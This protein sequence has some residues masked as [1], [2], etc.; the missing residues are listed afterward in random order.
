MLQKWLDRYK[1]AKNDGVGPLIAPDPSKTSIELGMTH[2]QCAVESDKD[3]CRT[4]DPDRFALAVQQYAMVADYYRTGW[5]YERNELTLEEW[6]DSY[7]QAQ[8]DAGPRESTKVI[9]F[10][11]L[12][13]NDEDVSKNW[14]VDYKKRRSSES[15]KRLRIKKV[16]TDRNEHPGDDGTRPSVGNLA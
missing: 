9:D 16:L 10:G 6:L 2:A 11:E 3:A 13:E 15:E 5:K 7:K 12:E 14:F 8:K 1:K 4:G